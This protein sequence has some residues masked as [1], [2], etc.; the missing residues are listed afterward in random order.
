MSITRIE[1]ATSDKAWGTYM[2]YVMKR[3]RAFLAALTAIVCTL[4]LSACSFFGQSTPSS[5]PKAEPKG[6]ITVVSTLNQWGAL[7]RQIG[8]SNVKVTS[9]LNSI[10]VDAHDF[11]PTAHDIAAIH[12]AQVVVINGAGYDSWANKSITSNKPCVSAA[13]TVGA[14][15]GDNPHL[16]FSSDARK[17][18]ATALA[19][20]FTRQLPSKKAQFEHNLDAWNKRENTLEQTMKDFVKTHGKLSYAATENVA[21]YLLSDLGFSNETP[22]GF[23]QAIASDSEPAPKDIQDM[24]TVIDNND[25]QLFVDNSQET[26]PLS[27]ELAA[28]SKEAKIPVFSVTEQMP[29]DEETLDGWISSLVKTIASDITQENSDAP[30]QATE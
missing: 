24:K 3:V 10:S 26:T 12:D 2:K 21:M 13:S 1:R 19:D 20:T 16:W 6:P 25:V 17:A 22:T 11:E 28:L 5:T 27:Q 9:I 18:V 15:D 30:Q 8:G 4:S 29:H 7:A 23:E 14:M